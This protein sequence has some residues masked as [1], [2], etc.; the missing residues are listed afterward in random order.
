MVY[1]IHNFFD[2]LVCLSYFSCTAWLPASLKNAVVSYK[3]YLRNGGH[4]KIK[5]MILVT[6]NLQMIITGTCISPRELSSL[7][8]H[9]FTLP[10]H[11]H[12]FPVSVLHELLFT[13]PYK[14]TNRQS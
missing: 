8:T 3:Y 5:V 14:T 7:C 2:S 11:C 12:H 6:M 10:V 13:A 9:R 1:L 4:V